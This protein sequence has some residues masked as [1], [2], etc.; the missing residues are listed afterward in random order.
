MTSSRKTFGKTE[1]FVPACTWQ[2]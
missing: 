2:L 1:Q